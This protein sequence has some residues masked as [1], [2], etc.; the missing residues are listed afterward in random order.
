[1]S[2]DTQ[3]KEQGAGGKEVRERETKGEE[4]ERKGKKGRGVKV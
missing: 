1:M 2:L 3:D 4:R